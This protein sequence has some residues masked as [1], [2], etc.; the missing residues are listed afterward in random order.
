MKIGNINEYS[1]FERM[2][3]STLFKEHRFQVIVINL[4]QNESL[5]AHHSP[6]DAFLFVQK[7]CVNFVLEA[8]TFL[9]EEGA[10]FTFKAFQK[11]S[12]TALKD[13]SLLIVK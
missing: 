11:H 7:G 2:Q 3:K 12:V 4:P 10:L 13:S 5:K 6:T 1:Q 8:E 9:L